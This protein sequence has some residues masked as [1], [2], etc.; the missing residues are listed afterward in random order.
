M[1]FSATA[2]LF[3]RREVIEAVGTFDESLRSC[4]DLGF[5]Q[6][7]RDA[8]IGQAYSHET[9]IR[10][11]ARH[12]YLDLRSRELRKVAGLL[13]VL[14]ASHNVVWAVLTILAMP[15]LS[16]MFDG[17]RPARLRGLREIAL[18]VGVV[19]ALRVARGFEIV[20][21]ALGGEPRR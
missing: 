15:S 7:V 1:G 19:T 16:L 20:R 10:H 6:R 13:R 12:R 8:G 4:G 11:H 14:S 2:N 3:V 21:L 5:G 17:S 18:Y 9:V